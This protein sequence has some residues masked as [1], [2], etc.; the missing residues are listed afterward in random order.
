LRIFGGKNGGFFLKKK[1]C[2]DPFFAKTSSI[3]FKKPIFR[4]FFGENILKI[5]SSVL[6][7]GDFFKKIIIITLSL[8]T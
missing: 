7:N 8:L 1:Q 6:G 5:I 2:F 3:L 4:Q